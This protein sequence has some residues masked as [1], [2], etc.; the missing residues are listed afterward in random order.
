MNFMRLEE[1]ICTGVQMKSLRTSWGRNGSELK[2]PEKEK[3]IKWQKE[4]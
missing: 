2:V 1:V 3:W 4:C